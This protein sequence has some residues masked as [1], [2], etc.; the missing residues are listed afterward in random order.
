MC[1]CMDRYTLR[2]LAQERMLMLMRV[3]PGA[4]VAVAAS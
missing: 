4:H 1:R 2:D 3:S